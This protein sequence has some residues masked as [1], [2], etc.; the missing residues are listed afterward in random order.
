M[1][2]NIIFVV[3]QNWIEFICPFIHGI[4]LWISNDLLIRINYKSDCARAH[5]LLASFSFIRSFFHSMPIRFFPS[6]C[7]FVNRNATSLWCQ[8][9]LYWIEL[10]KTF[11]NITEWIWRTERRKNGFEE[12]INRLIERQRGVEQKQSSHFVGVLFIVHDSKLKK[13][14]TKFLDASNEFNQC[15]R[16]VILACFDVDFQLGPFN[17]IIKKGEVQADIK[18]DNGW[19]YIFNKKYNN[20][21]L[22]RILQNHCD[23]RFA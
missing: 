21:Y 19:I 16:F 13:E 15:R 14:R 17:G 11:L 12:A 6:K 23:V 7:P 18:P 1:K 4:A 8:S 3:V 9:F 20:E 22:L 2:K 10:N 5:H